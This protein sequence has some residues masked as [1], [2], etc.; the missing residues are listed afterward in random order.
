MVNYYINP[1][2]I[3]R[4]YN[5]HHNLGP[6][7]I[8]FLVFEVL[9]YFWI[10]YRYTN[11]RIMKNNFIRLFNRNLNI[12][13][14]NFYFIFP[15]IWWNIYPKWETVMHN[16]RIFPYYIFWEHIS[17]TSLC[18]LF[19]YSF[20]SSWT[21]NDGMQHFKKPWCFLILA[22]REKYLCSVIAKHF[23]F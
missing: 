2:Y 10:M 21:C 15:W 9:N 17:D 22:K 14:L 3:R 8:L 20:G 7:D 12:P 5:Y 13:I 18:V 6:I 4:E 1:W 19:C 23:H 11:E 16:P